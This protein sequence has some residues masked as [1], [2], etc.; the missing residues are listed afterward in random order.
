[1][2]NRKIILSFYLASSAV[3]WILSR[4]AIQYFHL[5]FYQIR[6]LPGINIIREA[7]PVVLAISCFLI[8]VKHPKV[9]TVLEEVVSEL[10]KVT[11]PSREEVIRST[12]VVLVCITIASLVLASFDL[13][14]GKVIG[15]L[16][17]G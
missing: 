2:D 4:S 14:F 3:L 15:Y 1:M 11:W 12:T 5:T 13:L 16:L 6:R 17:K 9:N 8:L 7:L 10:K